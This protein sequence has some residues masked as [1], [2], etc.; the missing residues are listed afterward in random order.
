GAIFA[1]GSTT[2]VTVSNGIATF[3]S[4]IF[5][6][7]GNYSLQ[8]HSGLIAP[9]ISPASTPFTVSPAAATQ[10]VFGQQPGNTVAGVTLSP[11]LTVKI[12]DQFGNIETGDNTSTLSIAINSGPAG[13]VFAAGSTTSVTV[14]GGIATFNN[15]TLNTAGNYTLK[16]SDASPALNV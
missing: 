13:A 7:A 5:D 16:V 8:A 6:T 3:P 10:L 1:G 14:A 11:A 2:S 9:L 15:L 4:L 12:E